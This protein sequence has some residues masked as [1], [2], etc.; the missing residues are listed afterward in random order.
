VVAAVILAASGLVVADP[1]PVLASTAGSITAY[2]ANNG[3]NSVSVLNGN[4]VAA[5]VKV[6]SAPTGVVAAPNGTAVYVTNTSSDSISVISPATNAVISTI[7]LPHGSSPTAIAIN[8]T[9][10]DL[11]VADSGTNNVIVFAI[12]NNAIAAKIPVGVDPTAIAVDPN[13]TSMYVTNYLSN[14]VS[15]INL[16]TFKVT[17]TISVGYFPSAVTISYGGDTAYVTS[18]CGL[19]AF[20]TSPGLLSVISTT[21]NV[22]DATMTVGY[23]PTGVSEAINGVNGA[24]TIVVLDSCGPATFPPPATLPPP[25]CSS[26]GNLMMISPTTDHILVDP[27]TGDNQPG[28]LEGVAA[29]PD[30]SS[31]Y[32]VNGCGSDD[33]CGSP[34]TV[35]IFS[36]RGRATAN[37]KVGHDPE[38]I[39]F[40]SFSKQASVSSLSTSTSPAQV[41]VEGL[42][43]AFVNVGDQVEYSK[44]NPSLGSWSPTISVPGGALTALAPA[45]TNAGNDIWVSWTTSGD[46]IAYNILNAATGQWAFAKAQVVPSALT[47]VAP[48]V[49]DV[50]GSIYF[51][52]KGS[53]NDSLW[54]EVDGASGFEGQH[55]LLSNA[56][57]SSPALACA[58][59]TTNLW[60]AYKVAGAENIDVIAAPGGAFGAPSAIP[61]AL[62][63]TGPS[64]TA[65]SANLLDVFWMGAT[66]G[67]GYSALVSGTWTP[68]Q[69][70]Q[71]PVIDASPNVVSY[72]GDGGLFLTWQGAGNSSFWYSYQY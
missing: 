53:G 37:V 51:A 43:W 49:A 55:E 52:W 62:T 27:S 2:V 59:S 46:N 40:A 41:Y 22:V 31:I 63:L 71:L 54:Y 3:S 8:P 18:E 67:I 32:A 20:C 12:F 68:E 29:S 13:G 48:A 50:E 36:S 14:S 10:Q 19:D 69:F 66:G 28:M 34:G 61:Q 24:P 21:T 26:S 15:A 25:D 1:P 35:T 39:A 23:G 56:T 42:V 30:G 45:V 5:T 17:A 6:G 11:Y 9:G 72:G 70:F 38:G 64:I 33:T 16:T 57:D 7:A 65:P 47:N 58:V 4:A 44:F 60:L